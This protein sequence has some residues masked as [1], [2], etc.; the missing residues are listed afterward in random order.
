MYIYINK[1][2]NLSQSLKTTNVINNDIFFISKEKHENTRKVEINAGREKRKFA[3]AGWIY[4]REKSWCSK[5]NMAV[6]PA[7]LLS[8]VCQWKF[9]GPCTRGNFD[10]F[11]T[12]NGSWNASRKNR[13]VLLLY[14]RL[15]LV[16][17]KFPPL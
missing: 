16:Q 9:Y 4:P 11:S 3:G 15:L 14:T 7:L 13:S 10:K 1:E 2:N 8:F 6:S 17:R 12:N 5:R